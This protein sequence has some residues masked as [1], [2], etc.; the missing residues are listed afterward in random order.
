[1]TQTKIPVIDLKRQHAAI[2]SELDETLARVIDSG[3]FMGGSETEAFE[4]EWASYCEKAHGVALGCG[5]AAL[6]LTLRALGIGPGDEVVTVAFTLSATLDAIVETGATPVLVD[7]DPKTYTMDAALLAKRIGPKTKAVLPVHIYG[8]PADL[9]TI[10][11]VAG[12]LPVVADA[13]EAHGALYNG[14][15]VTAFATA[16]C[17]SFYPTKNLNALGDA[18]GVVTDDEALRDKLRQLRSHGWDRRF[19]SAVSAMN[20]RMDELHA[21]VLRMKLPMLDAWNARRRA[22]ARV[23]HDAL[24]GTSVKPSPHAPWAEPSYYLYVVRTQKREE[25]RACLAEAGIST[26]VHWP[27]P[28]HLQPAYVHLG[29]GE[30]SLPVTE[31]LC[32]EVVTVPMFPEMTD[33]EV[34][35]VAET[36]RRFATA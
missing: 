26:D 16:S 4:N 28:P 14:R 24:K 21:A 23:Y 25:L 5:T 12:D 30:G 35:R 18:G 32:N 20:S 2:R 17:F 19:H 33:E 7:V 34:E 3:Y 31:R 15:A 11:T 29:Y 8:H 10:N 36:L 9:D 1:V 27:E 22:I 6:N 13:C